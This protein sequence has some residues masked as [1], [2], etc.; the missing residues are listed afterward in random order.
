MNL[1]FG[2]ISFRNV[3]PLFATIDRDGYPAGWEQVIGTP[4]MINGLIADGGLHG[5]NVSAVFALENA[6]DLVMLPVGVVASAGP[7]Q[8]VGLFGRE[9]DEPVGIRLSE[10]SATANR[11]AQL[12][13]ATTWE[14]RQ[15]DPIDETWEVVIG[16][17]ALERDDMRID[18]GEWWFSY[19][20]TPMVFGVTV[21]TKD[22]AER[23]P[24]QVRALSAALDA[25]LE[26]S[27]E[28][29]SRDPYLSLLRYRLGP[30]E[31]KGLR[32]LADELRAREM[33]ESPAL[34]AEVADG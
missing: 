3:A 10:A 31:I 22:T 12:Y 13:A 23:H 18:L 2:R 20:S 7:V 6:A 15:P 28:E 21:V 14:G 16:D 32:R 19:T 26:A 11:L 30:D 25:G 34:P 24:E 9:S 1:R 4:A 29:R 5:G 33:I 27:A 17:A 8:S